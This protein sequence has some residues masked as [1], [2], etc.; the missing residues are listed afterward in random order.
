M[1]LKKIIIILIALVLIFLIILAILL[2]NKANDEIYFDPP[3]SEVEVEI[4]R[5]LSQVDSI[6]NYYAVQTCINKFYQYLTKINTDESE[7]YLSDSEKINQ[8][9][10]YNMLDRRYI[11]YRNITLENIFDIIPQIEESSIIIDQMYVS[12]KNANISAYIVRGRLSHNITHEKQYFYN[13]VEVDMKNRT[14]KVLLEDYIEDN[15]GNIELGKELNLNIIDEIEKNTYNI[16]D[17]ENIQKK[18]M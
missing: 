17:Y 1:K 3:T 6:N 2:V 8:Q 11:D 13:I 9:A 16:F 12:Q 5:Q 10:I 14:F 7:D 4:I 15:I 18:L